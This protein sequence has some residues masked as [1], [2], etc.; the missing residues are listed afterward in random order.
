MIGLIEG[1][2]H[3][4]SCKNQKYTVTAGDILLFDPGDNHACVQSDDGTLDYRGI[5]ITK[6]VMLDLAEEVAGRRELSEFS[7]NVIADEEVACYLRPLHELVTAVSLQS[8]RK[9]GQ[10]ILEKRGKEKWAGNTMLSEKCEKC[11][12][13]VEKGEQS[14]NTA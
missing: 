7:R 10:M 9:R 14:W 1:G 3:V 2:E 13:K 4:L 6:E 8:T 5:N 11:E 12:I